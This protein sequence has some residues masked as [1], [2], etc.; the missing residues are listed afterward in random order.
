MS[1]EV[2]KSVAHSVPVKLVD[3]GDFHTQVT[4]KAGGDVTVR[5]KKYGASSWSAKDVSSSGWDEIGNG[6][7]EIDFAAGDYDTVGRF[8]YQVECSGCLDY[9]GAVVVVEHN[10]FNV[11]QDASGYLKVK[12][13]SGNKVAEHVGV[14]RIEEAVY[15]TTIA[16]SDE[17]GA[18]NTTECDL[19]DN[20]IQVG[21]ILRWKRT[22]VNERITTIVTE[23]DVPHVT[24]AP[25]LG[26]TPQIGWV[27][28]VIPGESHLTRQHAA[29][30]ASPV[31]GSPN[32]RIKAID[33]KLPTGDIS[34]FDEYRG[35]ANIGYDGS[36]LT[37]NAWLEH[38]GE[39]VTNPSNC[40]VTIYNDAG[41]QQ[42][43]ISDDSSDAQGVFKMTKSSPGLTA[44][45]SYYAKVQITA[46]GS[47]YVTIEGVAT[48]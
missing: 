45:K 3:D 16:V 7:Y 2:Q 4:G 15:Q 27:V 37:V 25:A 20:S 33:D 18:R 32:E 34:D 13:E 40:I 17:G 10:P 41:T 1:Y 11:Q 19:G 39:V 46:S 22:D 42:F 6:Y 26:A 21:D 12:N 23:V 38:R 28:T 47:T 30:P 44:G 43:E 35:C 31:S 9:N 24:W 48:L 8:D 29:I 5:Y 36:T 14:Q